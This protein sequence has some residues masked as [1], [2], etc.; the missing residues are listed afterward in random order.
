MTTQLELIDGAAARPTFSGRLDEHTK[1]VGR[2][3]VS[4]ARAALKEANRRALERDAA[5]LARRDGE[6]E[7]RAAAARRLAANRAA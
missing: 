3:G 6:L 2:L 5:R 4:A 7:E 1:E